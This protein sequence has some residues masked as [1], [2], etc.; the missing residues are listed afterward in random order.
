MY[1]CHD[2][3]IEKGGVG[4]GHLPGTLLYS[5]IGTYTIYGRYGVVRSVR[6]VVLF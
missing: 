4:G 1:C 6:S 2:I 5:L 3:E